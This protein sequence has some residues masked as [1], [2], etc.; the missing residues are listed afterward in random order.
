M[1]LT[2]F[3][4]KT[5]PGADKQIKGPQRLRCGPFVCSREELCLFLVDD[6]DF[7]RV[8]A[9]EH[10]RH[11]KTPTVDVIRRLQPLYDFR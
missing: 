5:P 4:D 3:I 8:I 10:I 9:G 2:G 7:A 1:K 11:I 6:N